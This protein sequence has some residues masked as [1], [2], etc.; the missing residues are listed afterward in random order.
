MCPF[1]SACPSCCANNWEQ[2][3]DVD[4]RTNFHCGFMLLQ[5]K[6]TAKLHCLKLANEIERRRIEGRLESDDIIIA[7]FDH[8]LKLMQAMESSSNRSTD[9]AAAVP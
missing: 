1:L 4:C 8:A 2:N 7:Q 6:A 9:A 3:G 5:I